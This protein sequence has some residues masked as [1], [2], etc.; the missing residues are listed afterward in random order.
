VKTDVCV[1]DVY[2]SLSFLVVVIIVVI[3]VVFALPLLPFIHGYLRITCFSL[4]SV[5]LLLLV[6][7]MVQ[8]EFL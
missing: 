6:T 4:L 1:H 2:L 3:I 7:M 5:I 8:F